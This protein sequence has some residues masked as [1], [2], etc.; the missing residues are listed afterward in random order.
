MRN[1]RLVAWTG[2]PDRATQ[3]ARKRNG[4]PTRQ[5][6]D[7]SGSSQGRQLFVEVFGPSYVPAAAAAAA[8]QSDACRCRISGS[9]F[10]LDLIRVGESESIKKASLVPP[11]L[12]HCESRGIWKE[13]KESFRMLKSLFLVHTDN[14]IFH[15]EWVSSTSKSRFSLNRSWNCS[16]VHLNGYS[17]G[18]GSGSDM[19]ITDD[20]QDVESDVDN[21]E[22]LPFPPTP[23]Q[24]V[25][26]FSFS[27]RFRAN[28]SFHVIVFALGIERERETRRRTVDPQAA[29]GIADGRDAAG[30]AQEDPPIANPGGG[31]AATANPSFYNWTENR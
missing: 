29:G 2:D 22:E 20:F 28:S 9:F 31:S 11:F 21:L 24:N 23:P 18:Y 1:H 8:G 13:P 6:W 14:E 27:N 19:E 17:N 3:G 7:R 12:L 10:S 4:R 16:Q 26:C 5:R 15:L 30:A 25:N